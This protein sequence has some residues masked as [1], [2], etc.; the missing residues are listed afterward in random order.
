[1]KT[2]DDILIGL[3]FMMTLSVLALLCA[4]ALVDQFDLPSHVYIMTGGF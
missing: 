1:M 4:A 3:C 2:F